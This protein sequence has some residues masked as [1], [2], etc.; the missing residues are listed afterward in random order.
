[1]L[2][3]KHMMV[4]TKRE[5]SEQ[6]LEFFHRHNVHGVISNLCNGTATDSTLNALSLEKTEK[7]MFETM[8]REQDMDGVICGLIK[9]MKIDGAGNGIA[10][11]LPVDGVGSSA[12]K[13]FVGEGEVQKKEEQVMAESK[14]VLIITIVDKGNTELVMDAARGA[15]AGGGTVMRAKGTGAEI[16]K[17]FGVSIS[18]EKEMVYI[19]ASRKGRDDIMRAIMDKAGRNTEAHGVVFSLPVDKV[20]GIRE[21]EQ[22]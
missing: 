17:F 22:I 7:L 4:I 2:A 1:M 9:E 18:E 11:F 10:L 21:F 15:G 3:L 13:F 5:F 19:V 20:I 16:A 8:I 14:S 6:Y 12:L